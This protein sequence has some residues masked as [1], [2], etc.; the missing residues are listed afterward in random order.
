[1]H[2]T[3]KPGV[4]SAAHGAITRNTAALSLAVA[5]A[6]IGLKA[7]AWL[8]SGSAAM[9]S[10]LADSSLDMVASLFTL[11]AV[12]YASS[13]P[14]REHRYGHGKAEAFAGL[15][16]AGLV[17]AAAAF[18]AMDAVNQLRAPRPIAHGPEAIAVMVVSIMITIGLVI[19]QTRA[20]RL[21]G[22]IATRADRLH[23]AGDL[24]ANFVVALGIA[25]STYFTLAWADGLAALSVAA[26]LVWGAIHVGRDAADNL[27]DR[28]LA[29]EARARIRVL[30]EQDARIRGVHELR[31]R[32][33][34]PYMHVQFHADLDPDLTLEQAHKI[35]VAAEE[36]IRAEFPAADIIIHPDPM[37]RA[38]AHGH[39]DFEQRNVEA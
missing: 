24:G 39:E 38:A 10:S 17:L 4:S 7:W 6:L 19:V 12:R 18:I 15:M 9:L 13:P 22:S 25:A 34:G 37:G 14:D 16:Q 20:V 21:T 11:F 31:T 26:Y 27:L 33:S 32:A 36:R 23:Y 2:G 1:M 30:A 8:A 35:V 28:E 5:G 29:P 3:S